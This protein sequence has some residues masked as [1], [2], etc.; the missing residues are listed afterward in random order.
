MYWFVISAPTD[1]PKDKY[2]RT[3]WERHSTAHTSKGDLFRVAAELLNI[4]SQPFDGSTRIEQPKV[5]RLPC[6]GDLSGMW[7]GPQRQAVT[8]IC[9]DDALESCVSRDEACPILI[10]T[11]AAR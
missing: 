11:F 8:E 5:L 3:K 2:V 7:E 1:S 6:F 10:R 9:E 4:I